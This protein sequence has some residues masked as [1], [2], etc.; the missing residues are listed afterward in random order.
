MV[1][2]FDHR[3][4][5]LRGTVSLFGFAKRTALGWRDAVDASLT[6]GDQQIPDVLAGRGPGGDRTGRAVFEVVR[7]RSDGKSPGPVVGHRFERIHGNT[8][9]ALLRRK[10]VEPPSVTLG[11]VR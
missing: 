5:H 7:V 10:R 11:S 2:K 4:A 8:V 3:Y 1:E 6:A 9:P